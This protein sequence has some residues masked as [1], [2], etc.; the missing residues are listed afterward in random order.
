V[1]AKEFRYEVTLEDGG[2]LLAEGTAPLDAGSA[3]SA[4]HLVV[5]ALLRCSLQSLRYHA[6]RAG[7]ETAGRGV[8]RARVTKRDS[9]G[10]YAIVEVEAMLDVVVQPPVDG[11]QLRELL[12]KAERDCFVGASLTATPTYAWRVN[13]REA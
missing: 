8:G 10:R 4:D 1:A 9:D 5:A 7:L 3:W 11:D 2:T 6:E 12:A 13:G